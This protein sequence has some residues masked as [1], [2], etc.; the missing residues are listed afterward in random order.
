LV[1]ACLINGIALVGSL[2]IKNSVKLGTR[3]IPIQPKTRVIKLALVV[4]IFA[5]IPDTP[6]F[7][8]R[9]F[10]PWGIIRQ[11]MTKLVEAIVGTIKPASEILSPNLWDVKGIRISNTKICL[12]GQI[13][14]PAQT[15]ASALLELDLVRFS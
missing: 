5:R 8:R 9:Y 15:K 6:S 13:K 1:L 10:I 3:P 2:L 4:R 12:T 7:T 11:N 14:N